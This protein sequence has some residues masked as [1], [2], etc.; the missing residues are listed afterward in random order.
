MAEIFAGTA[1]GQI[2][3][4]PHGHVS[5]IL[6]GPRVERL[7]SKAQDIGNGDAPYPGMK[8]F[9]LLLATAAALWGNGGI[10]QPLFVIERNTN[11]NVVHYDAHLTPS[12]DL[13]AVRPID[14]YWIMD[15]LDGRR[16]ELNSLERSR[17][18]G[19]RVEPGADPNSVRIELV[20]QKRRTIEVRR[21]G[22]VVRAETTIAG[23]RAYLSRIFVNAGKVLAVPKVKSIELYG[24]DAAT[25][26]PLHETVVP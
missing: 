11:A 22:G 6:A 26:E 17:A 16:E 10:S 14:A 23:R 2:A 20:A 21:E 3:L 7:H 5:S 15:A 19:F 24:N 18:Y 12:G 25:G 9:P 1:S 13:D 8:I 4:P